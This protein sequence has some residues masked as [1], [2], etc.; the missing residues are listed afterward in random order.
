MKIELIDILLRRGHFGRALEE[1]IQ[2]HISQWPPSWHGKN[3]LHSGGSFSVMSPQER[4]QPICVIWY[5][6]Q[7]TYSMIA[8]VTESVDSMVVKLL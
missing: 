3:P 1:A 6:Q 7:L 4:V 5:S 8:Y 2:T